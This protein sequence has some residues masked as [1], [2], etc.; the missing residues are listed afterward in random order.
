MLL[1]LRGLIAAIL[2]LLAG[3]L[4]EQ[5]RVDRDSFINV[6]W[7]NIKDGKFL[8]FQSSSVPINAHPEYF[9]QTSKQFGER[10][11]FLAGC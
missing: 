2:S 10:Q 6:Q 9:L 5:N 11:I 1:S 4:H 8:S 3:I 7:E